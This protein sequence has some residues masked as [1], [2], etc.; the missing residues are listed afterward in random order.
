VP[1]SNPLLTGPSTATSNGF[2]LTIT[3]FSADHNL[4]VPGYNGSDPQFGI[5][6]T[7][8]CSE[9]GATADTWTLSTGTDPNA[10]TFATCKLGNTFGNTP[11][12]LFV[13]G[14]GSHT[15]TAVVKEAGTTRP[16]TDMMRFPFHV[17]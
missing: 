8:Q 4:D 1:P 13:K 2:I 3:A 15:L 11:E 17:C 7:A 5:S 10:S 16:L 9:P 14:C 12:T 6:F